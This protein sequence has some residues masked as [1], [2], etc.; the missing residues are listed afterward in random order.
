MLA[1]YLGWLIA[2]RIPAGSPD[3]VLVPRPRKFSDL[4]NL[5]TLNLKTDEYDEQ[6]DDH[7]EEVAR[8]KRLN[9]GRMRIIW[10]LYY[11]IV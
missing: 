5:D 9:K 11:S 4:V 8:N 2:R 6:S 10:Q 1:M 3:G 7:V